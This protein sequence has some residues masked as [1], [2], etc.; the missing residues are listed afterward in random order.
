MSPVIERNPPAPLALS[1]TVTERLPKPKPGGMNMALWGWPGIPDPGSDGVTPVVTLNGM[2]LPGVITA[3]VDTRVD[4]PARPWDSAIRFEPDR[5]THVDVTMRFRPY[6]G[7]SDYG[8]VEMHADPTKTH[9]NALRVVHAGNP[10]L[11]NLLDI[12]EREA[13]R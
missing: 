7:Y 9:L 4:Y 11:L 5:T 2:L 3:A 13:A 6:E 8:V 10:V 1:P 12:V